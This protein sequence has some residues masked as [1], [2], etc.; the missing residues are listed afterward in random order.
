ME[1]D[2]ALFIIK[3]YKHMVCNLKSENDIQ[4]PLFL[5]YSG[6]SFNRQLSHSFLH[7]LLQL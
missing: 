1:E 4:A 5:S 6:C 2:I 7:I 3:L